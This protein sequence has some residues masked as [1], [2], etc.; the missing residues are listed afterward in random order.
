MRRNDPDQ[1]LYTQSQP[2][3]PTSAQE[4]HDASLQSYTIGEEAART[5]YQREHQHSSDHAPFTQG[6]VVYPTN[7]P[8]TPLPPTISVRKRSRQAP[9]Q[10]P[11]PLSRKKRPGPRQI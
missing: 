3:P 1:H 6:Q 11:L 4:P 2:H 5:T 10:T 7:A 9:N 8:S